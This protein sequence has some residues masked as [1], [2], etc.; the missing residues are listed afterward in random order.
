[1]ASVGTLQEAALK[2]KEKLQAL[3]D[4]QKDGG[5]ETQ[6]NTTGE[7]AAKLPR[8]VFRSYQPQDES[9]KAAQLPKAK[10]LEVIDQ[11]RDQL[12]EAAAEPTL[13]EVDLVKLAPRKPDWDLKR[14][15]AK[16]LDKLNRRTQRAIA[17]L[18]CERLQS[19][20]VDLAAVVSAKSTVEAD[21]DD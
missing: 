12:K 11:V 4:K 3:R 16:K 10:P 13:D 19:S 18:I 21:E 1:M 6:E 9:L 7:P 20:Q 14:D 8:P 5:E 15:I 2:R 17:K